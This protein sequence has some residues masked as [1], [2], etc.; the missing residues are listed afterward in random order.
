MILSLDS[1][2]L[3]EVMK[4][5]RPQVRRAF[6]AAIAQGVEMWVS[7][8]IAHEL[9]F[10]AAFGGRA[11]EQQLTDRVLASLSIAPI[12]EADADAATTVRLALERTGRRIGAMDLLIAGQALGRGWTLVTAN[13]HE[14]SRV[15]GLQLLDWT[16]EPI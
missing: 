13:T 9:R 4:R 14:F 8:I 10:G 3:I 15:P 2:A 5:R 7:V 6:E 11:E 12:T 16:T 1:N